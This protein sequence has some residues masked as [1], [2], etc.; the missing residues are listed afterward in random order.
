MRSAAV[1]RPCQEHE[2]L[3]LTTK[4]DKLHAGAVQ[5]VQVVDIQLAKS[6]KEICC[7]QVDNDGVKP[8]I[9]K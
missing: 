3:D 9:H 6:K 4:F 8:H 2:E 1:R 5:F 7:P